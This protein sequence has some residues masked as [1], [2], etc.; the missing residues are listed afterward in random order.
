M[1][2]CVCVCVRVCVC[3][4]EC[5]GIFENGCKRSIS[6]VSLLVLNQVRISF[7]FFLPACLPNKMRYLQNWLLVH[8][9]NIRE[10]IP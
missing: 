1:C 6:R 4:C 8:Y 2:V 9:A 10:K 3:V 5:V 7:S